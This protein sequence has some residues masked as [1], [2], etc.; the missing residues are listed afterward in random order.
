MSAPIHQ[1]ISLPGSPGRAYAALLSSETFTRLSGAPATIDGK[2]GGAFSCF[3]GMILGRTIE[4]VPDRRIV[5]AW[6]VKTWP[7]GAYSIVRFELTGSGAETR[8][9]MDHDGYPDADRPHLDGGWH[10]MYW[11]PLRTELAG[12]GSA[13]GNR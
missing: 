3:G 10:K 8:L 2:E 12:G 13:A 1:E 7:E 9:V 11:E 4:L 6:R 5:Q